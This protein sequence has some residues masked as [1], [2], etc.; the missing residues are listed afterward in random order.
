MKYTKVKSKFIKDKI[1][2]TKFKDRDYIDDLMFFERVILNKFE[3]LGMGGNMKLHGLKSSYKKEYEAIFKELDSKAWKKYQ[4]EEKK[5][6]QREKAEEKKWDEEERKEK[7]EHK[8][9][10]VEAGGK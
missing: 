1:N 7:K 10:W 8:K 5:E 3:H 9:A 2:K 6:K 4:E